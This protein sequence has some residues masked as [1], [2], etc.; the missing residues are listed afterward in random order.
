LAV[1]VLSTLMVPAEMLPALKVEDIFSL[2]PERRYAI[3]CL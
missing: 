3:L 1:R 2:I